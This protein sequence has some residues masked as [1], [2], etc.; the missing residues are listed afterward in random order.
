MRGHLWEGEDVQLGLRERISSKTGKPDL[1][2]DIMQVRQR[3]K[4]AALKEKFKA[5]D[6]VYNKNE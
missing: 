6:P 1:L 4:I 2:G 3:E 5:L